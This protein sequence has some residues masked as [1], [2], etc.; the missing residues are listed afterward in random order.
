MARGH[1]GM[2]RLSRDPWKGIARLDGVQASL[3][4]PSRPFDGLFALRIAWH[5]ACAVWCR[6]HVHLG[7]AALSPRGWFLKRVC[8]L[9]VTITAC[10]LDL[11]YPNRLYQGM[12]RFAL[13]TLDKIVCISAARRGPRERRE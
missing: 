8:G 11:T 6:W 9:R 2:Q 5:C 13:P 12:I 7:D 1:G 3:C 4:A 10:G